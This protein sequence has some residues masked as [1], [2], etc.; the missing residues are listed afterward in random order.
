MK[1][2]EPLTPDI[3]PLIDVVFILLIFFLVSSTFKKDKRVID[4]TLPQSSSQV[5]VIKKEQI[6]I[7][8]NDTKLSYNG[9][10]ISLEE[11][12]SS[13]ENIK[14]KDQ[15]IYLSI[16]ESVR[17]KRIMRVLDILKS[18]KLTNLSLISRK[19]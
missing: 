16:D 17:Y 12:K 8:L 9:N 14:D 18:L 15:A 11:L 1:R 3:T 10:V 4:L 19:K 13:L 6:S 7:S 2:R 5:Q